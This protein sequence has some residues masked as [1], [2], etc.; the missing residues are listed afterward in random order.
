MLLTSLINKRRPGKVTDL[1]SGRAGIGTQDSNQSSVY[2][3]N[4]AAFSVE[5]KS[6]AGSRAEKTSGVSVP[7]SFLCHLH[8]GA[9]S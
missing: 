2:F 8:R 4:L 9:P 7:E 5:E 3:V 1:L 6:H